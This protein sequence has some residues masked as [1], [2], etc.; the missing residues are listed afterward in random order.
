[1]RGQTQPEVL[2]SHGD[3]SKRTW[4]LRVPPNLLYLRG[5]FDDRP[6]VPGVVIIGWIV[7]LVESG[8]QGELR[9]TS[10]EAIKFHTFLFPGQT[11]QITITATPGRWSFVVD[12]AG[13]RVASGRLIGSVEET[14]RVMEE[15]RSPEDAEPSN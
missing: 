7:G 9:L 10:L 1:M 2:S 12:S 8:N 6:I 5:H 14:A 3:S 4:E 11:F 15:Q 13:K